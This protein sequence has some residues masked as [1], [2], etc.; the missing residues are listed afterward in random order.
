MATN[1]RR[2][3]SFTPPEHGGGGRD[4]SVR[5]TARRRHVE[6]KS[7]AHTAAMQ[8]A[9]PPLAEGGSITL[10]SAASAGGVMPAT[11]GGAR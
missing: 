7:L 1:C 2:G 11:D 5:N 3:P 10:V 8:A 6:V 4:S 9:L